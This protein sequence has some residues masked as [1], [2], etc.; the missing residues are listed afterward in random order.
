VVVEDEGGYSVYVVEDVVMSGIVLLPE[1]VVPPTTTE[2]PCGSHE[3]VTIGVV[4]DE[5]EVRDVAMVPTAAGLAVTIVQP[6]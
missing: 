3:N 1:Y 5:L 2:L 4:S 6:V